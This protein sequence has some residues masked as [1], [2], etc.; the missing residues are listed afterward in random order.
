VIRKKGEK[1]QKRDIK[2]GQYR[3]EDNRQ[4]HLF[5]ALI[6]RKTLIESSPT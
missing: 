3:P 5:I 4:V 1:E 6:A 2:A